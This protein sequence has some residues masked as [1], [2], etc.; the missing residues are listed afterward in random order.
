MLSLLSQ[1]RARAHMYVCVCVWWSDGMW[2][3]GG[4]MGC[5]G[6]VVV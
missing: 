3:G 5:G 2:C 1:N 4:L 6:V